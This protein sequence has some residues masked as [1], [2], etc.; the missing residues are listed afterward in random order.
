MT[1]VHEGPKPSTITVITQPP[2]V[3]IKV[4]FDYESIGTGLVLKTPTCPTNETENCGSTFE[5]EVDGKEW[6][7]ATSFA[8]T[9][10]NSIEIVAKTGGN[11]SFGA[12][13]VTGIRHLFAAWP[14]CAIYNKESFPA[15]PFS[16]K[17]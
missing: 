6:I 2:N 8:Q 10:T 1:N 3:R 15:T 12:T 14:L 11:D 4:N 16:V 7:P 17:F 13:K 9:E 5:V